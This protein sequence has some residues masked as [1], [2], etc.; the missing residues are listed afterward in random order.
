MHL[1]GNYEN[2]IATAF[3]LINSGKIDS[4]IDLFEKLTQSYPYTAKGFL[5][6]ESSLNGIARKF[7]KGLS[8]KYNEINF[9]L[10]PLFLGLYLISKSIFSEASPQTSEKCSAKMTIP[11]RISANDLLS[12]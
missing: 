6:S 5:S 3:N 9:H 7:S 1:N 4:A 2:N 11:L 12:L 10:L 8:E